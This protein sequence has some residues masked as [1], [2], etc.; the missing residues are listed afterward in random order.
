M[1]SLFVRILL[2]FWLATTVVVAAG[3][4]VYWTAPPRPDIRPVIAELIRPRAID[5]VRAL[6]RGDRAAAERT[7]SELADIG[8]PTVTLI[9]GGEVLVGPDGPEVRAVAAEAARTSSLASVEGDEPG[10]IATPLPDGVIAV[11]TAPPFPR[12]FPRTLAVRL[13]ALVIVSGLVSFFLARNIARPIAAVRAASRAL[14]SGNTTVRVASE[15]EG[16]RDELGQLAQDFDRMAERIA[17]LLEAQSRLLLDVSHELRSPLARLNVGIELARQKVGP[18]AQPALDRMARESERLGALVSEVLTLARLEHQE[19]RERDEVALGPLVEE[20]VEAA[21]FEATAQRK[22]VALVGPPPDVVV[23]ADAE[24]LRRAVENVLRNAVRFTAAET[25]VELT[26]TS[27]DA[28][29][30]LRVRD[31]G[32]GVPDEALESIFQPFYRVGTARDRESGGTGLG[33]A[34]TARAIRAHG[35]E[36]RATNEPGGGLTVRLSL[37]RGPSSA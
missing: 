3:T 6:D 22:H 34:I 37:P 31:H 20:L 19:P 7:L 18:E 35:G 24:L 8:G 2:A 15:V 16:R 9:R 30:E 13:I 25:T 26:A 33:L 1:R 32:A 12:L 14:A 27:S 4:L 23:R 11:G 28:A 10:L 36:V 5:A 21:D 29:I 17:A